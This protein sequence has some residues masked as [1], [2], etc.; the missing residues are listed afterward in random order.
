MDAD[1]A[2]PKTFNSEG[3]VRE[4][5]RAHRYLQDLANEELQQFWRDAFRNFMT[6]NTEGKAA[7][8]SLKHPRHW[9]WRVRLLHA[10]EEISIR[11]GPYPNGFDDAFASS[12]K[13]P[14]PDSPRIRKSSSLVDRQTLVRGEHLVK[15]GQK[16]HILEML[17]KGL[18]RVAPASSYAAVENNDAISDTELNFTYKFYNSS[19]ELLSQ[20]GTLPP[21]LATKDL[22]QGTARLD[23]TLREDYYLFCLSASYDPRLFD[24]FE[25]DAC[26]IIH[27]P[28]E[29]LDRIMRPVAEEV[30]AKGW[31][32]SDVT[33]IDPFSN[34]DPDH[35][36]ALCKHHRYSYQDE[37]RAAWQVHKGQ[38][39]DLS[40]IFVE[41]GS[42]RDI[43]Y[44]VS[45]DSQ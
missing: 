5:Y 44:V 16:A 18:I 31:A 1:K 45:I 29:F 8:L 2:T 21:S 40:A 24:D 34:P 20:Y 41:I 42:L 9:Y 33:Y 39:H 30:H 7:P 36:H 26:M 10:L 25:A 13:F 12:V 28:V 19:T 23:I 15:Y 3:A 27:S 32:F 38:G 37:L 17:D 22:F 14:L 6:I 11:F 4:S 35:N 43:A